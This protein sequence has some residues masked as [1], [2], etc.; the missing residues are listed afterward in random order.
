[1]SYRQGNP[2]VIHIEF[3]EGCNLRCG[4]CGLN[5]I[6]GKEN[7]YKLMTR[8]TAESVSKQ[9]ASLGWNSRVEIAM[10]GEPTMN[11]DFLELIAI[12][13]QHL[14]KA[15]ILLESNGG[16]IMGATSTETVQEMFGAGLSTLALD[17]YQTIKLV[18]KIL[19]KIKQ[20][21][22][23]G[24][25]ETGDKL[26]DDS[27]TFYD[28]P[29]CGS[30]GNPH[31]RNTKKR[32]IW[33]RPIDV[34][35]SG[36]HSKLSNHAGSGAP[37]NYKAEGRRCAKPFREFN[38][39]WNGEVATCCNDWRGVFPLGSIHE[40]GLDEIWHSE[41]MYAIRRK[42]YHGQRDFG[43][44]DGCDT[45]SMRPG[46]LPDHLGKE[47]LPEPSEADLVLIAETLK[48]GPLTAPVLRSWELTEQEKQS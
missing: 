10:H 29:S 12:F 39:R 11:P 33:I 42:L 45:L 32:L 13:R 15:Y 7:D 37:K 6:R 24:F 2:Y 44:C 46:I 35:T 25:L 22:G 40:Q 38:V 9:M 19:E 31:K 36:T 21:Q 16:G 8:E 5:A 41:E 18:P 23:C 4:F 34:S 3:A 17:E 28:Y 48:K 1:M 30:V 43:A 20:E 47:E 27:V 26:F 14:P